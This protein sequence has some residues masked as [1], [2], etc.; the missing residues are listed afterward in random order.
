MTWWLYASAALLLAGFGL[1]LRSAISG[2][3]RGSIFVKPLSGADRENEPFSF[4]FLVLSQLF[5]AMVSLA[6]G[7]AA[8]TAAI[9]LQT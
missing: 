9:T 2:L 7:L 5:F 8:L 3:R 6:L 1:F 4:W